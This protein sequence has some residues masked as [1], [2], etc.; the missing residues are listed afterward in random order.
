MKKNHDRRFLESVG[1]TFYLIREGQLLAVGGPEDYYSYL[2]SVGK[3]EVKK[4]EKPTK[5]PPDYK[6][7]LRP[8]SVDDLYREWFNLEERRNALS[9]ESPEYRRNTARLEE[10]ERH[11]D[12][13]S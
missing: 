9:R 11:L 12:A 7:A 3:P 10:I 6:S 1:T 13:P 2:N 8:V 5:P 4:N